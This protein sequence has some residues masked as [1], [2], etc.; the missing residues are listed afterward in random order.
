MGDIVKTSSE[1]ALHKD[2]AFKSEVKNLLCPTANN[3]ELIIFAKT[4]QRLDLDPFSRQI[5]L[6]GRWDQ[7]IGKK[8]H[9]PMLSIDGARVVAERSGKY[10]GQEDLLWCGKDGVWTDI[11]IPKNEKDFPFAAKAGVL[12][13]GSPKAITAIAKWSS[14]YPGDKMGFMWRKFPDLMIGKC[15]EMLALRKAF[16]NN[17]SGIYSIDEMEQANSINNKKNDEVDT[18]CIDDETW[19]YIKKAQDGNTEINM[20]S[21][22]NVYKTKGKEV[23]L[24]GLKRK[25]EA[26]NG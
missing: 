24:N 2:D 12:R 1:L 5:Y 26:S 15:A 3:E 4:C 11:W 10:Q 7:A 13:Q 8:K 23:V 25:I 21:L 19:S 6:I 14:Y 22:V 9:S 18:S 20:K 16:P 17:L